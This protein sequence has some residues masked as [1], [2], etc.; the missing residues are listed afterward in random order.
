MQRQSK[1]EILLGDA[2]QRARLADPDE[3]ALHVMEPKHEA[4][5]KCWCCPEL[6]FV[7]PDTGV[8]VYEHRG[9][10]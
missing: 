8:K 9:I 5:E 2:R 3:V 1:N 4:H 10:Q 7:D 6:H